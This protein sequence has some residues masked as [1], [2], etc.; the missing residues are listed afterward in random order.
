MKNRSNNWVFISGVISALFVLVLLA[1]PF[2][3]PLIEMEAP[4]PP[5]EGSG[6]TEANKKTYAGGSESE[7]ELPEEATFV[8]PVADSDWKITSPWGVRMSPIYNVYRFHKGVD[9]SIKGNRHILPQIV[10]IAD[11]FI[12]HHWYNHKT[13]GRYIVINHG[14]GRSH[15]AH[16]SETYIHERKSNGAPWKVKAGSII[17]RMG[18]TGFSDGAHL[19]FELELFVAGNSTW[20]NPL[21]YLH[22]FL[23]EWETYYIRRQQDY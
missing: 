23:P 6:G 13:R 11:G 22:E 16:L 17:G 10:A 18:S 7:I 4:A 5:R 2:V 21:L 9:I 12:E 19:H 15:Y 14:W 1:P 3:V 20:V 8:F